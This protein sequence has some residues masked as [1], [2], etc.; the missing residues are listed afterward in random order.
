M[1]LGTSPNL[2]SV[3]CASYLSLVFFSSSFIE[4]KLTNSNLKFKVYSIMIFKLFIFI[5]MFIYNIIFVSGV[6]HNYSVF[7]K[8]IFH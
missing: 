2:P 3:G 1:V 4:T 8:V 7:L 5:E 6:H